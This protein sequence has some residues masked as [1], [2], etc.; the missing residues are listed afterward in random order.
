MPTAAEM[1]RK[2]RVTKQTLSMHCDLRDRY[3]RWAVTLDLLVLLGSAVFCA[4]R[5]AGDDLFTWLGL[6]PKATRLSLGAAATV[7][8]VA[9]L[10]AL[11][12]DWKGR[13]AVHREA[14]G[15]WS[16]TLAM[17]RE[18][19][20]TDGTWPDEKAVWLSDS[21]WQCAHSAAPV[22]ERLFA[23]LKARHLA[24]VEASR[25]QDSAPGCPAWWA[26]FL[27]AVRGA[28]RAL[29]AVWARRQDPTR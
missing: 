26:R 28:W 4:T 8:F 24:K 6:E 7:S 18:A 13:A 5:F 2:Y 12:V 22:P 3:S 15:R 21:Y 19:R 11:R 27:I 20:A 1:E 10:V 16:T 29:C 23:S 14:A 9:S 25:L 17:F